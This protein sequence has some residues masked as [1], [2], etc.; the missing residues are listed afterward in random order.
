MFEL[1]GPQ[2]NAIK[3]PSNDDKD[4][5]KLPLDDASDKR[6]NDLAVNAQEYEHD[7]RLQKT[8]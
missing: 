5:A 3:A 2:V 6:G 8:L 1:S 4:I 7:G